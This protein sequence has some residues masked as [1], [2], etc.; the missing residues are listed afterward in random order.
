ML[1]TQN[2]AILRSMRWIYLS[3]HF[4]DAVLS[5]GG[6]IWE[7]T[8]T[9]IPVEIWTICAG[10]PPPGAL[11]A[12]ATDLH[13]KWNSGSPLET[14]RLRR[15]EDQNAARRVG[16]ATLH[17]PVPDCIYRRSQTGTLY[18]P[19]KV[20]LEQHPREQALT[21]QVTALLAERLTRHD[22]VVCP[23][24]IVGHVD[25]RIVRAAAEKLER[26]LWYYSDVP[27]VLNHPEELPNATKGLAPKI[28]FSS[29]QGTN[30][31]QE[32]ILT[33]ASQLSGLF[34]DE[35]EMRQKIQEY[36]QTNDGILLWEAEINS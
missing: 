5:C 25:H 8:H 15:S 7:Q 22:T 12:Q 14:V 29:R 13:A 24:T 30:A 17:L 36:R 20:F 11:S 10:D 21:E 6:L 4:D 9:G 31:W 19:E 18:Y 3:P 26:P 23:L 16:A 2:P 35:S 27:Y 32:S 34:A 1:S 28:F 33:Y